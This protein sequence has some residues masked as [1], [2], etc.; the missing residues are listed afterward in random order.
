MSTF[1]EIYAQIQPGLPTQQIDLGD[2][3]ATLTV[4][5]ATALIAAGVRFGEDDA[6]TIKDS[7]A[8]LE[9]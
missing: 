8:S 9:G 6:V 3:S 7:A 1:A 5:E 2:N 4:A